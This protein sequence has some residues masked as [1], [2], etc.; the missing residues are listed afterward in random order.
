MKRTKNI[1]ISGDLHKAYFTIVV[2]LLS[3]PP[4]SKGH[5]TNDATLIILVC[6]CLTIHMIKKCE[7]LPTI[8]EQLFKK[9]KKKSAT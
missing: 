2:G 9:K 6:N 4:G 8:T 1:K 7:I 5:Y 3:P